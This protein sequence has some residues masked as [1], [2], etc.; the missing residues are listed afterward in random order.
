MRIVRLIRSVIKDN[1]TKCLH[2]LVLVSLLLAMCV[3][4]DYATTISSNI[5]EPN[6]ETNSTTE[7]LGA[8]T[9]M[10]ITHPNDTIYTVAEPRPKVPTVTITA[11]PSVASGY[12]YRWYTRTWVDYCPNC[13]RYNCLLINPK[14][15]PER[16]LT[17]K[18]CSSDFCGVVGKEK[19]SWSNVYLRSY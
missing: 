6:I 17:C 8:N 16:E 2:L 13:H 14:G 10:I 19:Y 1:Y 15:V 9:S 3:V 11:K 4:A 12:S 18:Y 5:T 7:V